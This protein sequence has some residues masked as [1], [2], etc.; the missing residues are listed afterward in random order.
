MKPEK[1]NKPKGSRK[2]FL[3][4]FFIFSILYIHY[5]ILQ[6]IEYDDGTPEKGINMG[7]FEEYIELTR[8]SDLTLATTSSW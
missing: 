5:I 4:W 7:A 8:H 2:F 6:T 3:L 1:K